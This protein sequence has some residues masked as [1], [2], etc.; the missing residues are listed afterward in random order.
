MNE[1]SPSASR[2]S[3]PSSSTPERFISGSARA[4]ETTSDQPKTSP[5]IGSF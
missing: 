1:R 4:F 5:H 2:R 3:E